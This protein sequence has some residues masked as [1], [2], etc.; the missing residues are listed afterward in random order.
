MKGTSRRSDLHVG[1]RDGLPEKEMF[2][3]RTEE[4]YKSARQ[5]LRREILGGGSSMYKDCVEAK[6]IKKNFLEV[7]SKDI[8]GRLIQ[9]TIEQ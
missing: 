4:E 2:K 3:C 6:D 9:L 8:M 7:A 5:S 1:K